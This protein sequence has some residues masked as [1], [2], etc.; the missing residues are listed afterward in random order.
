MA[1]L[2]KKFFG[3]ISSKSGKVNAGYTLTENE[4]KSHSI[5]N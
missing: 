1:I 5:M 4:I 2:F 3:E